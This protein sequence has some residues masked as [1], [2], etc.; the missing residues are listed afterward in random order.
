MVP[1]LGASGVPAQWGFT[2]DHEP[3]LDKKA[4]AKQGLF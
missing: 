2:L 3:V 4:P 1:P